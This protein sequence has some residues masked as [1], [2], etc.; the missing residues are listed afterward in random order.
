MVTA[1]TQIRIDAD[2]K[3]EAAAL[4]KNLGLD[5]SGAVNLFLH[6]CVLRGGLPFPIEMPQYSQ[7]TLDAMAEAVRV[8]HDPDAPGYTSMKDLKSALE[9]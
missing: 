7:Q 5:M 3:K 1:P 2:I 6:Q 8:S 9:S 4:F